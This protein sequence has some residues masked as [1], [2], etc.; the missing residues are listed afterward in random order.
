M[1][2]NWTVDK[3]SIERTKYSVDRLHRRRGSS[4]TIFVKKILLNDRRRLGKFLC[5]WSW[6]RRSGLGLEGPGLGLGLEGPGLGLGLECPGLGLD[7]PGLGLQILALTTTLAV[8]HKM[9]SSKV[10]LC[11]S[12]DKFVCAVLKSHIV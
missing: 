11:S 1:R 4:S 3:S 7:G 8:V 12:K 6:P 5:P 2:V 10:I 9:C